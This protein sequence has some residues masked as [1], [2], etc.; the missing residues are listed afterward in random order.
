MVVLHSF[1]IQG[2]LIRLQHVNM[3]T[4]RVRSLTKLSAAAEAEAMGQKLLVSSLLVRFDCFL[5]SAIES[6]D[7][8]RSIH[9][10]GTP[11]D[12]P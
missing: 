7:S 6:V 10:G 5:N 2:S 1:H 4:D 9:G 8:N 3:G 11:S 12:S